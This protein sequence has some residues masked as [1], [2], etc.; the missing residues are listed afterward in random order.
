MTR[1]LLVPMLAT[2]IGTGLWADSITV[3]APLSLL[4]FQ[5][6]FFALVVIRPPQS[7]PFTA[8]DYSFS[9]D[10]TVDA[11]MRGPIGVTG[12]SELIVDLTGSNNPLH[13]TASQ[14]VSYTS[15][16]NE[17]NVGLVP[18]GHFHLQFPTLT[19][20]LDPSIFVPG[21]DSRFNFN[22][23]A[24]FFPA[25]D[26]TVG[27]IAEHISLGGNLSLTFH[28][29]TA[30]VVS[31]PEPSFIVLTGFLL[32]ALV[33]GRYYRDTALRTGKHQG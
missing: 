30:D 6:N 17:G 2:G 12:T 16:G 27:F 29:A 3:S 9:P 10:A 24:G 19:G 5:P 4:Y 15:D 13:A 8:V 7:G 32:L 28:S 33:A 11:G 14:L 31:N 18:N 20:Q 23:I 21:F 1:L 25:S 22:L 26:N